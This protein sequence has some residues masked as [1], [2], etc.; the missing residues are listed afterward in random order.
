MINVA[1]SMTCPGGPSSYNS[2]NFTKLNMHRNFGLTHNPV[3]SVTP[4]GLITALRVGDELVTAKCV[5]DSGVF[6]S[7][8]VYVEANSG[9]ES[10]AGETSHVRVYT[11]DGQI[12]V[13][14]A[15]NEIR[16]YTPAGSLTAYADA[17]GNET[18]FSLVPGFYIVYADGQTFKVKL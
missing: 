2:H 6:D 9:V 3:L 10:V 18:G 17:C 15:R 14:G 11:A 5:D 13:A 1:L 16:I 4:D 12:I 8:H 7:I